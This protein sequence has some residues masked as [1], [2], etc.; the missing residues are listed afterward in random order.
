MVLDIETAGALV[1][2]RII[3]K[4]KC[5][6]MQKVKIL[7]SFSDGKKAL[8]KGAILMIPKWLAVQ[9]LDARKVEFLV[10]EK[11]PE[12]KMVKEEPK[13]E[14]VENHYKKVKKD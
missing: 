10:E 9:A 12:V 4:E 1:P 7:R 5:M 3:A 6:E 13:P 8:P 14:M 11:P 2:G